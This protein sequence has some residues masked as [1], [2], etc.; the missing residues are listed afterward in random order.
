MIVFQYGCQG[1]VHVGRRDEPQSLVVREAVAHYAAADQK[2][3]PDERERW[4][5]TFD[6]M[7]ARV[8]PRAADDVAKEREGVRRSRRESWRSRAAR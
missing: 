2:T 6:E 4:I 8:P 3:S 5:R 1:H 7:V